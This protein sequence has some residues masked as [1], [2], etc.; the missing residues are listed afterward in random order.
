MKNFLFSLK[1]EYIKVNDTSFGGSQLYYANET[2]KRE[3]KKKLG[4]CGIVAITDT[5]SYLQSQTTY[6]SVNDY[7]KAFDYTVKKS[8]WIPT[9]MGMNY[10]HLT[11]SMFFRLK[12]LP[13]KYRC[14]WCFSRKKMFGRIKKMLSK[15]IPVIISIPRTFKHKGKIDKLNLYNNDFKVQTT[16]CGHF[17]V[18]TG[19]L[20]FNNSVYYEVSS[21]GRKYYVNHDE[22]ISFQKKH[23]IGLL[24]NMLYINKKE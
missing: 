11:L 18:I 16:T 8:K 5:L 10:L 12:K 17:V 4:G 19:L 14:Y 23:I 22:F 7:K 9:K 21:W 6:N 15:D 20:S 13:E 3:I 1:K 24:G 2:S